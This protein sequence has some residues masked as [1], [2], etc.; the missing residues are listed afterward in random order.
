[1]GIDLWR[2][3]LVF[4]WSWC[5]P[6]AA[7][8]SPRQVV[9][10]T[11]GAIPDAAVEPFVSALRELAGPGLEIADDIPV[12]A[13]DWTAQGVQTALDQ[14]YAQEPD[15]VLTVGLAAS[16]LAIR[17]ES[18]PVPTV[19]PWVLDPV[20]QGLT[21]S[22]RENIYPVRIHI[23]LQRHAD[24]L[25]AV[26]GA[27]EIVV[28]GDPLGIS[29]LEAD[30][31]GL[32][33][34]V[35][36]LSQDPSAWLENVP[37]EIDGV[38]VAPLDRYRAEDRSDIAAS[39]VERGVASFALGGARDLES[40]FLMT[41]AGMGD[42]VQVARS[43]ALLG[44]GVLDGSG[45]TEAH[46]RPSNQ[47]QLAINMEAVASLGVAVP[48]DVLLGAEIVGETPTE[49]EPEG[50]D[51]VIAL[52]VAQSPAL[53]VSQAELD[54]ARSDLIRSW[55]SWMPHA[56]VAATA[57]FVDPRVATASLG[58]RAPASVGMEASVN[59]LL[60]DVMARTAIPVQQRLQAGRVAGYEARSL[61]VVTDVALAYVGA[62]RAQA[63]IE[64]RQ[65]DLLTL[66][67]N[68]DAA[69]V[70]VAVG[71]A[72]DAEEARW[73]AEIA[74]A[75]AA[76]VD[77]YIGRR[78]TQM[79]V[80]Q[81]VGRAPGERFRPEAAA[82]DE[83]L[84]RFA[85]SVV[86]QSLDDPVSL[87]RLGDALVTLGLERS[88]ELMQLELGI[89]AQEAY[90]GATKRAYFVPR[91]GASVTG[92]WNAWSSD[93]GQSTLDLSALGEGV[94]VA[95]PTMPQAYVVGGISAT[96]PLFEGRA[97]IAD[98]A[99]AAY[100]LTRLEAQRQQV[101]QVVE[102]R[103]RTAVL[104]LEGRYQRVKMA[105]I[106]VRGAQRNLDWAE[107]AYG[108][109]LAN[110]VQL[111]DARS[112]VLQAT[113]GLTDARFGF[114]AAIIEAK[115]ATALLAHP[116]NVMDDAVIERRITELLAEESE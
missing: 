66:Q 110:Q 49:L 80:N 1:M 6:A 5:V 17:Q 11:D 73:Q 98:Q 61:D 97:R 63:L 87:R 78:A 92:T 76:L 51:S 24:S 50:L 68:L 35:V 44:V 58:Q 111:L 47:G 81:L 75:R 107:D 46:W 16:T 60:Y 30:A 4:V 20:L 105:E 86:G 103:I 91:V 3:L 101:E 27:S 108:R 31:A 109:G 85:D 43:A 25:R 112:E 88:P 13:G 45:V 104:N 100:D 21:D 34:P 36:G 115:R 26:S 82:A 8:A 116:G 90:L 56:D 38:L 72:I 37:P 69:R 40:G 95:L 93:G 29:L 19:A 74:Q 67:G 57:G 41:R 28:L 64:V 10:V 54:A 33:L 102:L 114:L 53:R 7:W 22:P 42:P 96:L 9:V 84:E 70:R 48:F 39:L 55:S 99:E 32:G 89:D 2:V 18:A 113:V 71:D 106:S 65:A 59:Q 15:L 52:A 79:Q 12:I 94:D 77:A 23:G 14:A 83:L 62:L